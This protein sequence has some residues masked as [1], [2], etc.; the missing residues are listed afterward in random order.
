MKPRVRFDAQIRLI[1][2][3]EGPTS[4]EEDDIKLLWYNHRELAHSCLEAKKIVKIIDEVNGNYGAIDLEKYCVVGLEKFH[5]KKEK[6]K[7]RKLLVKAVLLKQEMNRD[8][9]KQDADCV[10]DVSA[11]I[12]SSFTEFALWQAAMHK[13]HAQ[14]SGPAPQPPLSPIQ[15]GHVTQQF[16][17]HAAVQNPS[18]MSIAVDPSCTNSR[19]RHPEEGSIHERKRQKLSHPI[20]PPAMAAASKTCTN[21]NTNPNPSQHSLGRHHIDFQRMPPHQTSSAQP[22]APSHHSRMLLPCTNPNQLREDIQKMMAG[23]CS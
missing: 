9:G 7:Y 19:P 20:P 16:A 14:S 8:M 13:F 4:L 21:H 15:N 10:C 1:P 2:T 11:M 3:V 6:E 22:T 18:N 12:S 17:H 5:N 23:F